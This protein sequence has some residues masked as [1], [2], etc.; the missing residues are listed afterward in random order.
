M[1]IRS[2]VLK[3][4][5]EHTHHSS[6]VASLNFEAVVTTA[7]SAFP[8]CGEFTVQSGRAFDPSI[9]L[10]RSCVDFF[11]SMLTP[12][13]AVL[14]V[15][16]TPSEKGWPTTSPRPQGHIHAWSQLSNHCLSTQ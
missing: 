4:L 3:R 13:Y 9:H 15:P 8:R 14:T 1:P 12:L 11:P 6:W 16:S 7:F 2:M 10:T 5:L